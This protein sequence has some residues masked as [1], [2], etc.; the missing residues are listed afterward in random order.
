[1]K[2]RFP[3]T[4]R[5]GRALYNRFLA[6]WLCND[7]NISIAQLYPPARA[8]AATYARAHEGGARSVRGRGTVPQLRH[9]DCGRGELGCCARVCGLFAS[10]VTL[11]SYRC[12][13]LCLHFEQVDVESRV[14]TPFLVISI[15]HQLAPTSIVYRFLASLA[16]LML[17]TAQKHPGVAIASPATRRSRCSE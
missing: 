4:C 11:W 2:A 15:G 6:S 1:M 10:W 17:C 7:V 12:C 8:R 5:L 3:C 14:K 13:C 9:Q 16:I